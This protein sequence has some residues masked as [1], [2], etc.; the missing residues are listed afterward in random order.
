MSDEKTDALA[1]AE[2]IACPW[3][4]AGAG[5]MRR[6]VLILVGWL[7]WHY[8]YWRERARLWLP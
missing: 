6:L 2:R 1:L 4:P 5:M 3:G 7:G 8:G